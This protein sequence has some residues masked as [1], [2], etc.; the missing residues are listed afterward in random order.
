MKGGKDMKP[1]NYYKKNGEIY[2]VHESYSFGRWNGVAIRFKNW[3]KAQEYMNNPY[4]FRDGV[5][6]CKEMCSK[7]KAKSTGYPFIDNLY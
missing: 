5:N 2:I 1:E 6:G 4:N 3:N 7:S